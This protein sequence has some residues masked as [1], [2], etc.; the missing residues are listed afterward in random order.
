[1]KYKLLRYSLL[2]LLVMLCGGGIFA[3]GQALSKA[4][5]A[6]VVYTLTVPT[7]AN[8]SNY[9]E[10]YDVTVDDMTWSV[11]GNQSQGGGLRIGGKSLDKVDR[12]IT[13]KSAMS[14]AVG[15]VTVNH[16][17]TTSDKLVVNSVTMT[18]A[19][20]ANFSQV[21]ETVNVTPTVSKNTDG[22]FDFEPSAAAQW[23][24][25]VYY[26]F[27][28]NI[29]N[30][31][32]SNYAFV[33]KSIVFYGTGEDTRSVTEMEVTN[34]PEL[35]GNVGETVDV[36]TI[37]VKDAS[38]A[39]VADA[40]IEWSSSNADVAS[41][42]D[43]KIS[44]LAAGKTTI[45]ASFAGNDLYKSCSAEFE[46]TV[47][48]PELVDP[49]G[50]MTFKFK[51]SGTGNDDSNAKTEIAD[52]FSQGG[53]Y[54]SEVTEATKVYQGRIG[55]GAKL[56]TSSA[57]GV[58]KFTLKETVKPT[59]ITFKARYYN[60]S[61]IAITVND[62]KYEALTADFDE[63]TI[64]Y[65]GNTEV[66]E[67]S[68]STPAKR[69]YITELVIYTAAAE[70]P[71][72]PVEWP[73]G[74]EGETWKI[75]TTVAMPTQTSSIPVTGQ[76]CKVAY[77]TDAA[78]AYLNISISGITVIAKGTVNADKNVTI[79]AGQI[80]GQYMNQ[81]AAIFAQ[82]A[83]GGQ[84][85]VVFTYSETDE[86]ISLTNASFCVALGQAATVTLSNTEIY[87]EKPAPA[88][89]DYYVVGNMTEWG[90][91]ADYQMTKNEQAETEEYMFTMDLT[92]QS[93]FKV[94][95]SD[96]VSQTWYPDGMGNNYGENGEITKDGNYTI[97]FR[98]KADGGDDWFYGVIYVAAA[99]TPVADNVIWSSDTPVANNWDSA[100]KAGADKLAN[101][102]VGDIIHVAVEGVTPNPEDAW[103][104]QVAIY[105]GSG[106]QLENGVP[107]GSGTV[108]DAAFV[109]T[110]DMLKLLK[111]NGLTVSGKGFSSKLVTLEVTEM[112]G[113]DNSIWVGD[114][115]LTWTQAQVTNYHFINAEVTKGSTIKL[116]FEATGTPNIQMK[117]GDWGGDYGSPDISDGVATLE[118]SE[119][120]VATFKE[121]GLIINANGIRLTQVEL[122]PAEELFEVE[123]AM[124]GAH[125]LAAEFDRYPDDTPVKLTITNDTD[126]YVSRNGWGIGQVSNIDNWSAT[127]YSFLLTGK[128]GAEFDIRLTVGDLKKA[129][130]NG[131]DTYVTSENDR[132]GVTIQV[133][134]NCSLKSAVVLVPEELLPVT[135]DN[136]WIV[137]DEDG[138]GDGAPNLK[139]MTF[140]EETQAFEYEVE[141]NAAD[142][143]FAFGD[144]ESADSWDAFT[145]EH[146]IAVRDNEG[147]NVVEGQ[148]IQ[149]NYTKG[150][151]TMYI[152]SETPGKYTLSV[153]K[154]LM[155][156]ITKTGEVE[157][158]TTDKLYVIGDM[159]DWDRTAMTEMTVNSAGNYEYELTTEA[160]CY[161]AFAT[162]QLTAEEA[163]ADPN[164]EVFSANYRWTIAA[165][166]TEAELDHEYELQKAD[167]NVVLHAGQYTVI[168]TPDMKM[169]ITGTP[170]EQ[171]TEFE[172]SAVY[173]AGNGADKNWLNGASWD[174]GAEANKLTEVADD[175]WE[176]T[177]EN[178]AAGEGYE[179]KFTVDG[180]W[181]VNFGIEDPTAFAFG[182][183]YPGVVNGANIKFSLTEASDVTMH[184]DMSAYDN[185]TK[186]GAK[187]TVTATAAGE[188]PVEDEGL[189]ITW[190]EDDVATAGNL[191]ARYG[192]EDF[193]LTYVDNNSKLSVD[194][195]NAF[196]GT[197]DAQ[198][199]F[200]HRLKSGGAS[201]SNNNMTL[202]IAKAGKLNVYARSGS[203]S[204]TDRNLVLTQ[205]DTELYNEVVKDADAIQV[206]EADLN[207][208]APALDEVVYKSVYPVI[209]VEVAAG[210]LTIGYPTGSMNFYAFQLIP[211]DGP[212]TGIRNIEVTENPMFDE[213]LPAYNLQGQ[214][215][216]KSYRGV[217]I[218]NGRKF[219]N[220]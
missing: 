36:P 11:P 202:H 95:K 89:A 104:A 127:D 96:G 164:W 27:T 208:S 163:E 102:K 154:D 160:D 44:F 103:S 12:V 81:P 148:P 117:H 185:T 201:N 162:K 122:L 213:S 101:A 10:V 195:S 158:V 88:A 180:G 66:S 184:L 28:F 174:A 92:T 176:I 146:R 30:P 211:D 58:L 80:V 156:S 25:N 138:W 65:D 206:A 159:N 205:G 33:V 134:N 99:E 48:E 64:S 21:I 152:S 165:G 13:G 120:Q 189:W 51:E 94:V 98:P 217:V 78:E 135:V 200:T 53:K 109:I 214:R 210:E 32:N 67:I 131:Q 4:N 133:Y 187:F 169:I 161:F 182:T 60:E 209:T 40:T 6:Q 69:A 139:A 179:F 155:L 3:I 125:M 142:F 171:P 123:L 74:V 5:E 106:A 198:K 203:P 204:A 170:A 126:P 90:V 219:Y 7:V 83:T 136:L 34:V 137:G 75:N 43:G 61:E 68:I 190:G 194:A 196:F 167:G 220:K 141:V 115:T 191:Q 113:S 46:F 1:M 145:N 91:K 72:T 56:G 119:D 84:E 14:A 212:I 207:V 52:I 77:L 59:R 47:T 186:Q 86:K 199:K 71:A 73:E 181:N 17:G 172:Y 37:T 105:D 100:I 143:Y 130:K 57:A 42:S 193:Y 2:S 23:N 76:D 16:G 70:E 50:V 178:V 39:T 153:T 24:A 121:K 166:N 216:T 97:Y 38:G 128:D 19:S 22:S 177:L 79:P 150:D 132:Q 183:E 62:N 110:G 129:A 107:V 151:A 8:N 112:T 31:N 85:D 54:V 144:V 116:T 41:V 18:V 175:V 147:V 49:A 140:N 197:A 108:S 82:G 188:E 118:V 55:R 45:K 111:A 87:K 157:P 192:E 35:T 173:V 9:N 93:Q 124:N 149:L 218:Q 215:V 15:K 63:Y 29:T 26:K 114:A 168:V 20:D